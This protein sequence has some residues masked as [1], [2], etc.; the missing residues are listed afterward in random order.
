MQHS[1]PVFSG[2]LIKPRKVRP[3]F[4]SLSGVMSEYSHILARWV[5][6]TRGTMATDRRDETRLGL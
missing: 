1:G 4:T 2:D 6:E 3:G 5:T